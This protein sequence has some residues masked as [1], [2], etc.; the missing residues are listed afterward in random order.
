MIVPGANKI[1][2]KIK[3]SLDLLGRELHLSIRILT[4][5]HQLE[6]GVIPFGYFVNIFSYHHLSGGNKD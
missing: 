4:I 2:Q 6:D 1:K 5:S 3:K